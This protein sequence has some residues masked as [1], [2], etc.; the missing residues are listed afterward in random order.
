MW[1]RNQ[2]DLTCTRRISLLS[3]PQPQL[4]LSI[5]LITI[6][7]YWWWGFNYNLNYASK[8]ICYWILENLPFGHK[9]TF[10]KTQSKIFTIFLNKVIFPDLDKATIK[11]SCCEISHQKLPLTRRYGWLYQTNQCAQKVG[12]PTCS[13]TPSVL[14]TN[15]Y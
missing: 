2:L 7:S 6:I 15:V 8:Q 9:Q 10:E 11:R 12:F 4:C 3:T 14:H 1:D 13:F 5:R